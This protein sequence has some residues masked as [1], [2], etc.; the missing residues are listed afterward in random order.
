MTGKMRAPPCGKFK[1]DQ[2]VNIGLY[3]IELDGFFQVTHVRIFPIVPIHDDNDNGNS[4]RATYC[5]CVFYRN[6]R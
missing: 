3:V 5:F 2:E 6:L 4:P 1:I